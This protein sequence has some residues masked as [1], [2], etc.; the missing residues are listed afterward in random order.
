MIASWQSSGMS[1]AAFS[2]QWGISRSK[3]KHWLKKYRAE[4]GSVDDQQSE[5]SFISVEL[6]DQQTVGTYQITYPNGVQ[7]QCP[8]Q[9][10]TAQL[11]SLI[12]LQA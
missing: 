1:Q 2:R 7:L 4:Q 9:I 12:Y 10:S 8:S 3:F 11:R 6:T 5:P